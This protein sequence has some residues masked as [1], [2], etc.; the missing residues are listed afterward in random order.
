MSALPDIAVLLPR[1][2]PALDVL[3]FA[4]RAENLGFRE[5]WVVEDLGYRGGIAQA[6]AVLAA[7][8]HM[9]IGIGILPAAVRNDAFAAMELATLAQLFP[10]RLVIGLG[11]GMPGWLKDVA[12]WPSRPLARLATSTTAIRTLLRG[13]ALVVGNDGDDR[14]PFRLAAQCVPDVAPPVLL[15]VRGPRSLALAGSIADGIVLA[16]PITPE[17]VRTA[18]AY[19]LAGQEPG[20]VEV[21]LTRPFQVVGYTPAVVARDEATDAVFDVARAALEWVGEPD[22]APHLAPLPFA[23]QLAQL[24]ASCVSRHEFASRLPQEWVEQLALVGDVGAVRVRLGELA[25]AGLTTAVL[26][27]TGPDPM[28]ALESLAQLA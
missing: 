26:F 4:R 20:A 21:P 9:R 16:E 18:L 5:L 10:G 17:Y 13:E 3:P 11:H 1:D 8:S 6:S 24:R 15:G 25:E 14:E 2:L 19:A 22:W 28:A 12:A 7:T 27:P 23:A